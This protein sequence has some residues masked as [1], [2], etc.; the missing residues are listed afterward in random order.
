VKE[1]RCPA[2]LCE[3]IY[4]YSSSVRHD[5]VRDQPDMRLSFF[6]RYGKHKVIREQCCNLLDYGIVG[7]GLMAAAKD[8]KTRR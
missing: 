3:L 2:Q 6:R 5:F 1:L 8:E 7:I 4:F